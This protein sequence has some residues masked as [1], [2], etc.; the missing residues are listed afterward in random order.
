MEKEANKLIRLLRAG[1]LSSNSIRRLVDRNAYH[2]D[3]LGSSAERILLGGRAKPDDVHAVREILRSPI[4][5]H[6]IQNPLQVGDGRVRDIYTGRTLRPGEVVNNYV[7]HPYLD[8]TGMFGGRRNLSKLV[9]SKLNEIPRLTGNNPV[10]IFEGSDSITNMPE[11]DIRDNA[12]GRLWNWVST[13]VTGRQNQPYWRPE[14][15]KIVRESLM[16][17]GNREAVHV[18][19]RTSYL[20]ANNKADYNYSYVFKPAPSEIR[21]ANIYTDRELKHPNLTS[22]FTGAHELGHEEYYRTLGKYPGDY[23][24]YTPNTRFRGVMLDA[25]RALRRR[26]L[27]PYVFAYSTGKNNKYSAASMLGEGF[28]S[29][30]GGTSKTYPKLARALRSVQGASRNG[31][32]VTFSPLRPRSFDF[33]LHTPHLFSSNPVLKKHDLVGNSVLDQ[34]SNSYPSWFIKEKP[35]TRWGSSFIDIRN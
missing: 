21:N 14:L 9:A 26:G 18:R 29:G 2:A 6:N 7:G 23:S 13:K 15:R 33:A 17:D 24:N 25:Y 8:S 5:A 1:K 30:L 12:L 11:R 28:A 4:G 35:G 34:M 19:S 22:M 3:R 32:R 16:E 20:P 27:N 10:R 31:V